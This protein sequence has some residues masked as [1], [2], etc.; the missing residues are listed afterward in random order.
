MGRF[1]AKRLGP[2]WGH[3]P[4]ICWSAT[5]SSPLRLSRPSPNKLKPERQR[6][7]RERLHPLETTL[8]DPGFMWA[9]ARELFHIVFDLHLRVALE[10]QPADRAPFPGR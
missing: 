2:L 8:C 3:E 5:F 4:F 9:F 7:G 1:D 10:A 6:G